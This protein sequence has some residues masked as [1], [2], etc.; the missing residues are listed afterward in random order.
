MGVVFMINY[1]LMVGDVPVD[2]ESLLLTDFVNFKIKLAHSFGCAHRDRVYMCVHM[3][4][5]LYVYKYLR[6][7]C[8]LAQDMS[9][10]LQEHSAL[11]NITIHKDQ[12]QLKRLRTFYFF[13]L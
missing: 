8:V 7:Y 12:G 9:I 13:N 2:S 4:D 11:E 6:L 5:Y 3:D 10:S 1:F